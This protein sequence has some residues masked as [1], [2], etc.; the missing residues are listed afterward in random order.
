MNSATKKYKSTCSYC[1]VG[2]GILISKDSRGKIMVEGDP[3]HPA[4]KGMLCSKG[5]NLHYTVQNKSDRLLFPEMRWNKGSER[6]RVSWEAAMG[7]I[8]TVFKTLI[9]KYGPDSVAFYVSG[10]LLTEEYYIVNKLAKGYIGTNNIDTNSRLCMSSAVVGY[11][12]SLGEDSV[13]ISYDDI[14]LADCFFISGANPAWCHPI[15]FRRLEKHKAE[16]LDI[17]IIVSDPRKTQS[18]AIA[19]LHLQIYPGTDIYLH[20]AIAR[21]LIEHNFTDNN[22]IKNHTNGFDALKERVMATSLSEA[23]S[24]CKIPKSDIELAA[25]WIGESKGFIPMWAMGLNQSAIG[26]DKNLSLIN[27]S[28]ITGRIGK[29]GNGPFSLTGQPNA[30]G[31]REV[32][33]LCNLLPAHRNMDSPEHRKEVADFWG[34]PSV[35]SVPGLSAT[36]MFEALAN[37]KLKAIWIIC[38]NPLVSLPNVR[39]AEEAL[40]KGRFVVVQDISANSITR[41][42]ADVVLPAASWAEK[43]GTMTNSDRRISLL[44]K[45]IDPPGEA[46]PDTEILLDFARRMGF[47]GFDFKSCSDIYNEHARLTAGTRIDISGLSYSWLKENGTTQ[48]P[49]PKDSTK[50]T[51][52]LFTD[53]SFYTADN[54]AKIHSPAPENI[55]EAPSTKYPLAL[56][57]GRIRDQWHTMTRTGKVARLRQ[58]IPEAFVEIHPTDAQKNSVKEGNLVEIQTPYGTGR[59][60]AKI[61]DEIKEGV[62]FIPMHWGKL[63]GSDLVRANN[64]TS[65]LVDA[66]S[67]EPD[68]KFTA[69]NIQV[70]KKPHEKIV[71]IGAGAAAF[72]FVSALR[73]LEVDD[74]IHV[75][76]SEPHP[77]YDRVLLPDYING[78][79]M[80][81]DLQKSSKEELERLNLKIHTSTSI[82]KINRERRTVIDS[83]GWEHS[84]ERLIIA[85]GSTPT[86]PRNFDMQMEGLFTVR[87]RKNA[88]EIIQYLKPGDKAVLVGA[89]LLSLEM[90]SALHEKNIHVCLVNRVGKVMSRQLDK[91]S[92]GL[93]T[94]ILEEHGTTLYLN[95]EIENIF[96][97][98]DG[99]LN[100][101]LK[102]GQN[103]SAKT[104]IFAI[105]TTPN[106]ELAKD[107]GLKTQRGVVVNDHLQTSDSSI[108]AIGE[109]AEHNDTLYGIT[110]V[111]EEQAEVA[112]RFIWG[113]ISALFTG[114]VSM[115]ILK[116]P[117]LDL[118]SI[119]IPE[120]PNGDDDYEEIIFYDKAARYYKK[121][122]IH[123]NIMVGAIL[124]GDKQE[125]QEFK[126]LIKQKTELSEIRLT[127]LRSG[128][129]SKP[130]IGRLVCSCNSVG[131]GNLTEEIH[132]GASTLDTLCKATGAGTACG[133][134]RPEVKAI[135]HRNLKTVAI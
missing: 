6:V 118:C 33:G 58:H 110:M 59:F 124:L 128:K 21:W 22:F 85:T 57:T 91:I 46:R 74:E 38:T 127:L 116:Y 78:S 56:T 129:T 13:P 53:Y 123:N 132:K 68:F 48:W 103:I 31:G 86:L 14:E 97:N 36:Q 17:R 92:A 60:K 15:L 11:K 43:E 72:K 115:N 98:E 94:N 100:I 80:W 93:L 64:L 125:F 29:P 120:A 24:V 12:L 30:M 133:S 66:R 18:T 104:V 101:M 35:P 82:I 131:E 106:I 20:H 61:T 69:A 67:K 135:L 77:F 41:D 109:I 88:E 70:Y 90:V 111:A 81:S 1:G 40:K 122:I 2:C 114:S 51:E 73:E 134:C 16:N 5:K 54:R 96:R 7:R 117:G 126:E 119:G 95:D 108:F 112:A 79:K 63:Q 28:L 71:V 47:K 19:D 9:S 37:D 3:D 50:G 99:S 113:D 8:V 76:S 102:S 121:C 49:F 55:S 25:R 65:P 39:L 26:V 84:Y 105:G 42:Y 75:F 89:G 27:L 87:T 130:V 4:N 34:V 107:C 23:A 10:Q 52:R 45:V 44:S 83:S 32:G 62:I